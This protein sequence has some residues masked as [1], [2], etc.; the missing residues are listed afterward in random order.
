MAKR[1]RLEVPSQPAALDLASAASPPPVAQ[2]AGQA[3]ALA[4]ANDVLAEIEA[5]R[6]DG[7]LALRVPLDTIAVDHLVRDRVVAGATG[8]GTPGMAADMDEDM[9]ALVASIRDH[10]QRVPLDVVETGPG[11][12]GLISGWRRLTALRALAAETALVVIRAPKDAGDAYLAMIEENEIRVGLS[13]Y[14]RARIAAMAAARGVF[15]TPEAAIAA[16]YATGS[17]AKRS[18]IR[19]FLAIHDALGDR[20][21]FPA[22]LPERLG[23]AVAG[24]LRAGQGA[25]LRAALNP[26]ARTAAAEAAALGAALRVPKPAPGGE[27]IAPGVM[28]E[29]RQ[30]KAGGRLVL[31]GAGVD[32]A[33]V[34]R[35]RAALKG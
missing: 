7:R 34:A 24:A 32:A 2:V 19:S 16:L 5:A 8:A 26:P 9:A 22:A 6:A 30:G 4:A 11:A 3:A 25:R 1:R 13:Y 12:Y 20:L 17:K 35:V 10:G 29:V 33:L 28:L 31:S 27:A 23:L 15:A 21:A 14:E 18:K